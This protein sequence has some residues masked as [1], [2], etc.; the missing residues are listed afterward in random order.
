M[1]YI[2]LDEIIIQS[3]EILE[4]RKKTN[5]EKQKERYDIKIMKDKKEIDSEK[6]NKITKLK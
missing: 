2:Y 6:Q 3:Y 5:I 4:K 1:E